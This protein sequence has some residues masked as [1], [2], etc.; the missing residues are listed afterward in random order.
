MYLFY[1]THKY[2]YNIYTGALTA[3]Y[4]GCRI[5]TGGSFL[6]SSLYRIQ[7]AQQLQALQGQYPGINHHHSPHPHYTEEPR[8]ER[9]MAHAHMAV[10]DELMAQQEPANL[11]KGT[12]LLHSHRAVFNNNKDMILNVLLA[13]WI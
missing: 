3:I 6:L 9:V 11:A 1:R 7:S 5:N 8:E 2:I 4:F 13:Q 12:L 10:N